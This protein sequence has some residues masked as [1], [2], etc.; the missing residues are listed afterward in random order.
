MSGAANTPLVNIGDYERAAA[1]RLPKMTFDYYAGGALDEVTL[2]ENRAAYD[3]IPIY[4]RTLVDVSR[5]TTATTVLGTPVSMPVLVAPTAFHG[6]AHPDGE[7]AT[8]RAAGA[9]GTLMIVSTLSNT[10]V[11]DIAALDAGPLWF[12]LYL[13]KDRDATRDLVAR[14]EAAG[15]RAIALTVD[16]PLLGP[17]ERDVRNRFALPGGLQVKNLLGTGQEDVG[18]AG[19]GSGLAS[20]VG[21]FLDPALCWKDVE[22]L[23]GI[24][25]LPILIKGIA[26]ADDARRAVD[27]GVS[28]VVVSNHGGRQL[29]TAP[30]TIDALP[31]VVDAV[32]GRAE[33]YVDGGVR[34]GTDVIKALARGARAVM[35]GRPVLWGLAVDGERGVAGV[36]ELLRNELDNALGLCGC[37]SVADVG[38]DLLKPD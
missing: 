3:R 28:G 37:A 18:A 16:A 10:R 31:Y 12:Q 36:L 25:R 21:S 17:R 34:R 27:S 11:E 13:Y 20:Y 24:T 23:R 8:A 14:V 19:T 6:M 26:R 15:C 9:A 5:R 29:D 30:A 22:W 1:A 38:P 7:L 4:Y 2:R 35:I 32:G 33:V